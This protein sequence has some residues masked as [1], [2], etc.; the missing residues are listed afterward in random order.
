MFTCTATELACTVV[1][2]NWLKGHYIDHALPKSK[3]YTIVFDVHGIIEEANSIHF[4]LE[5]S[6][7]PTDENVILHQLKPFKPYIQERTE[8][9]D[10]MNDT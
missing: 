1:P 5:T 8:Q 2:Q 7:N 10:G 4:T 9:L 3:H 6:P